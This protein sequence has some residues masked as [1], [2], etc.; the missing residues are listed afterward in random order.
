MVS[1]VRVSVKAMVRDR[2]AKELMRYGC[3]IPTAE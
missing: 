3:S 2:C 1:R